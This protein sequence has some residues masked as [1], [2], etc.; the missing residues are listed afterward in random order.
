[1]ILL[2]HNHTNS[3]SIGKSLKEVLPERF[4]KNYSPSTI[5]NCWEV[6][7]PFRKVGT[8]LVVLFFAVASSYG[9]ESVVTLLPFNGNEATYV[10]VQFAADTT[11]TGG[12]LANRV[13]EL[14]RDGV[15]L[16]RAIITIQSGKT[17]RFRAAAGT[18][19]KPIIYL[20]ESGTGATPTRP[21]GNFVVLNGGNLEMTNVGVAGFYEPEPERVDGVQGGLIN[22][23]A[24]GSSIT[25]DGAIFSNVNGQHVRTG[26]NAVKVSAKNTIFAD[27]GAL[28]TSNLGAG[29]G[30]DLREATIDTFIVENCTFV[31]YQDR[32]IR[33]YNF[34]NPTAGTGPIKYGR[35]NHNTFVN[36]MGYH[37]LLSL[38]N[39]GTDIHITNNLFIDAFGLGE[40][41]TDATR[42][43]EWA[44]TGEFYPN[45]R[46]RITWIFSARN[47][48][49]RWRIRNNYYSISDSGR[50]FL[51]QFSFPVGSP[52]SWHINGKLQQQGGDSVTAFREVNLTLQKIPKVMTTMMRWYEAPNGGTRQ[53][54]QTNFV[55]TRDDY[56][57]RNIIYYR[58]TLNAS[59]S[60][61]SAAYTAATGGYPVGDLNWFPTK[62]VQWLIDPA[63]SVEVPDQGIIPE[64]FSLDQNYPN[65][66]NPATKITYSLPTD[67]KVRLEVF[68]MLGRKVASLVD[69]FMHAGE[70]AVDFNA[71]HL[72]SGVYIYRLSTQQLVLSRKMM[73]IK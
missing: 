21:P 55:R 26:S 1:M 11:A 61:S 51:N 14:Q 65:P 4:A 53:K 44:N 28:T 41:S 17:L 19:K 24:V 27:M 18:G 8:M 58:D 54:V 33:H 7:M 10:N 34:S 62:K 72:V 3:S 45:G 2:N 35:I 50:G 15:Y 31:N 5:H 13:Y 67:S 39:V 64:T 52:L 60:T 9:Q 63:T 32:P 30:F 23:T 22:T 46:N 56:D 6:F 68:D 59:Y 16:S 49:T 38:G 20:W 25:L 43:A 70:H 57:R 69:G 48:T 71:Y 66:F 42:A 73:L 47:D 37:G 12:L 29:K 40:D 36:G